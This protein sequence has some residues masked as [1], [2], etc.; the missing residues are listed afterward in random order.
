VGLPEATSAWLNDE[1]RRE[2]HQGLPVHQGQHVARGQLAAHQQQPGRAQRQHVTRP[3]SA[4]KCHDQRDDRRHPTRRLPGV[5]RLGA[6][7]T[8]AMARAQR[9]R[10]RQRITSQTITSPMAAGTAASDR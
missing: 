7:A 8:R 3:V 6:P 4:Q 10:N 9:P 1:E 5:E 2:D